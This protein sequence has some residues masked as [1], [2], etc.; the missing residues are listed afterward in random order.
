MTTIE[1]MLT[2]QTEMKDFLEQLQ[3]DSKLQDMIRKLV[4]KEAVGNPNH[5]YWKYVSY[6]VLKSDYF[7][8]YR[9]LLRIGRFDGSIGDC[10]SL[11]S[12]LDRGSR[13]YHPDLPVTNKYEEAYD[14]YLDVIHNCFEGPEVLLVVEQIINDAILIKP[15]GKRLKEAKTKMKEQFH[16]TDKQRPRWIQGPEWPMGVDSPMQYTGQKRIPEGV[17]YSF[18]DVTNGNTRIVTQYY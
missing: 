14:L 12:S 16:V 1:Q 11:F 10:L 4:P 6:E 3:F 5:E 13:Y 17:A 9:L 7:D 8:Y 15:K 18:V 2:G